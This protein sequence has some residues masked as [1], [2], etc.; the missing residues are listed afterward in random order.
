MKVKV[1]HTT[2]K[3]LAIC[4]EDYGVKNLIATHISPRYSANPSKNQ[5]DIEF[6]GDEIK[7]FYSGNSFIAN[8]LD[9]FHFDK[10]GKLSL[11]QN[12]RRDG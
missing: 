6:L 3:K 9:V 4:A 2:A 1:K 5:L 8:D 11:V 7:E 10:N 12:Y